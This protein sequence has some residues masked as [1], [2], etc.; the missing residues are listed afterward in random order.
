MKGLAVNVKRSVSNVMGRM[1]KLMIYPQNLFEIGK[2]TKALVNSD[3]HTLIDHDF[4]TWKPFSYETEK[5]KANEEL[6]RC[7]KFLVFV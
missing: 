1:K 4:S 6:S 5:Y 2:I 7:Q 3:H